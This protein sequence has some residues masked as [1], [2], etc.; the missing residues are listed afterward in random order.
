MKI[1]FLLL[2]ITA[3]KSAP[4]ESCDGSLQ[5]G[6]ITLGTSNR[7]V[8]DKSHTTGGL[9]VLGCGSWMVFSRTGH[10]GH[11]AC[12]EARDG[13]M[14]LSDIGLPR[15]RSVYRRKSPCPR[16]TKR[17]IAPPPPCPGGLIWSHWYQ[18]CVV[19]LFIETVKR[20]T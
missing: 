18:K 9:E 5:L 10:R 3:V 7:H 15:V 17:S 8:T 13:K 11:E 6:D 12:V 14:S 16:I 4:A 20:I 2:A 1:F 19:P